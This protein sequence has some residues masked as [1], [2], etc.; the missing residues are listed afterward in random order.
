MPAPRK[1]EDEVMNS[2]ESLKAEIADMMMEDED[3][4]EQQVRY[5]DSTIINVEDKRKV[6]IHLIDEQFTSGREKLRKTEEAKEIMP[7]L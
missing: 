3:E 6:V 2:N 7:Y 1:Q 4:F 5:L